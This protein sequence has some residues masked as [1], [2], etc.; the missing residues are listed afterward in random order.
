MNNPFFINKG[1]YEIN[2]LLKLADIK[3][4]DS[5]KKFKIKDIKDLTTASKNDISFFHSKKY[6]VVA[7]KTKAYFCITTLNLKDY[8]PKNCNKIIVNNVLIS[9][10][11]IT[12]I[13]Y[14]DS[15][16]DEFDKSTKK[17]SKSFI[18]GVDKIWV[19]TCS[20][21]HKNAL[22]NYQSRGMKIF[23]S[24]IINIDIN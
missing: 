24:E 2:K 14:P 23:K 4:S 22:K 19:H 10:A 18:N 11:K 16:N 15:V 20:L 5:F 7:S 8:L 21:D 3:N 17:I 6:E 12:K 13:F 1:P 9:I